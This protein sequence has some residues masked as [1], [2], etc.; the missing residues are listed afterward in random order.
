MKPLKLLLWVTIPLAI[1]LFVGMMLTVIYPNSMTL[2][3]GWLC[4]ED[5]PDAFV[6]RYNVQTSDGTGTNFTLFCLSE[7]GEPEEVG[8]WIPMLT[9]M[10]ASAVAFFVL[11]IALKL[12]G[13]LRRLGKDDGPPVPDQPEPVMG[14]PPPD[15]DP[16][17]AIRDQQGPIIS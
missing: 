9:V 14:S 17:A 11:I 13:M 8:T 12:I 4:P 16:F 2:A 3:S 10:A 1:A 6:V 5:K 7:R 15:G